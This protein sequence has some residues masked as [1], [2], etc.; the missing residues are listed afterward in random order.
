MTSLTVV[1]SVNLD[2]VVHLPRLPAP[3]ET[4]SDGR[5][6]VNPGGKGANQALAARR[7]GASV[8]LVAAVGE[9]RFAKTALSLLE[10][11]GVGMSR[12]WASVGTPTGVAVI[13]VGENGQNQIGV[14]PGANRLLTPE[15]V[16]LDP[17]EPVLC[18]LEIP[19][20]TVAHVAARSNGFMCLNAAPARPLPPEVINRADL[21]VV[22]E[23]ERDF[24]QSELE[25]ARGMVV[26]TLGA[27][28]AT[29]FRQGRPVATAR[30]PQVEVVD[31]V[32][33]GDAFV[34]ALTV[35]LVEG[36][37]LQFALERACAAGA[38]ATTRPGAQASLP[39]AAEV[40]TIMAG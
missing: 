1:G 39:T 25:A 9:D 7:L 2:F 11:A 20:E 13:M 19:V 8:E 37:P 32:G 35:G 21:I 18:Q 12:C 6:A 26:V 29:A 27:A 24:Y 34:A 31:T 10:Q 22:N 30:P 14:A 15:T 17:E 36:T 28:G 40:A 5:F 3:G 23:S 33:A 38:L 4:V 16:E